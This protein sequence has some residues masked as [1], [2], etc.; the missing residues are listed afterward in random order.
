LET[1]LTKPSDRIKSILDAGS[2]KQ[3]FENVLADNAGAFV[4]SIIDLYNNDS[5]LQQC[6]PKAV[7]FEAL[8]AASLKLPINKQLGFSW[9]VAYKGKPTFQV[10]Y[11]GYIQ[12]AIRSGLYR[13]INADF[14]YD[15][16]FVSRDFLSGEVDLTGDKKGDKIVGYFAHLELLAGYRKTLYLTKEEVLAHAKRYS[17]SYSSASDK[18]PWKSDPD[19]MCLK[20]VLRMLLSK[21]ALLSIEMQKALEVDTEPDDETMQAN[22]QEISLM[23]EAEV[24]DA[25]GEA[26]P[27]TKAKKAQPIPTAPNGIV[28]LETGE[29]IE[30][31]ALAAEF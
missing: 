19:K 3:Q 26:K 12:L 16:Q 24:I 20:T 7:V 27:K 14:V 2:V 11:K 13:Y 8:K 4:A 6:E 31:D 23:Q 1:A 25:P 29:V 30:N 10:G 28:D 18:S 17:P 5:Q 22:S 21:Y 15:G 9:I